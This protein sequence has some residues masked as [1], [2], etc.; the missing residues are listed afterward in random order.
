MTDEEKQKQ[1]EEQVK[2]LS[3]IRRELLILAS[4]YGGTYMGGKIIME[5]IE[6]VNTELKK[7]GHEVKGEYN[8]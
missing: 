8:Q 2:I 7:W 1:A 3:A 4:R 5:L 6:V